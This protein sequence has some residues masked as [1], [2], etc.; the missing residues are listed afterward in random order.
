MAIRVLHCDDSL[1]FR[2]L[3]AVL[4]GDEPDMEVVGEATDRDSLLAG[5]AEQRPDVLLLDLVPGV[6]PADLAGT[7]VL[8]LTGH[9]PEHVDGPLRETAVGHVTKSTALGELPAAIRAAVDRKST[10]VH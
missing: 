3:V 2:R 8:L 5:L 4:L 10:N 6:T 1:A 9:P 7:R